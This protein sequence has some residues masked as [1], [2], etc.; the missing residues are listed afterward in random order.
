MRMRLELS[1]RLGLVLGLRSLKTHRKKIVHT[2]IK[3]MF[4]LNR[5]TK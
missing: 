3:G 1:L 4:N 5:S 2:S